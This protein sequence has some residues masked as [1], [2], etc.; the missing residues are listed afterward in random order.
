MND[1]SAEINFDNDVRE[2]IT[3]EFEAFGINY[4]PSANIDR[5]LLNLFTIQRKYVFPF[6]REVLFSRELISKLE[7]SKYKAE[8]MHLKLLFMNQ[9]DVNPFQS[10][11]LFNHRV[12]DHLVYDWNIYHFHLST[13]KTK[14]PYFNNRTKKVL[15]VYLTNKQALFLDIDN[16]PPHE[17]FADKKL[18]EIIDNNW[19][20]I[21]HE[22]N[23][24]L[25]LTHHPS[26]SER[27]TMRKNAI[28]HSIVEINGKF[29]FS[30]GMGMASSGDSSAEVQKLLYFNKWLGQN[31]RKLNS[32]RKELDEH[33]MRKFAL[34]SKIEYKLVFTE[35]GPE[36]W[37]LESKTRLVK[38]QELINTTIFE[39][40]H[41]K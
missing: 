41:R 26:N 27:F 11:H 17:V 1:V 38:Y 29:V 39:T 30:P 21:L 35:N 33:F 25:G 22:V 12:H 28:N 19:E 16:H 2:Y 15:F 23:D 13:E 4:V 34:K 31:L 7:R 32:F 9:G 18:L 14:Y 20:G 37:D 8:V 5:D 24:I 36:I 6:K 40:P 3:G 10:K